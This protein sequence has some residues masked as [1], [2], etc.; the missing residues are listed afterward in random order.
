MGPI[1]LIVVLLPGDLDSVWDEAASL[2]ARTGVPSIHWW[3]ILGRFQKRLHTIYTLSI[4]HTFGCLCLRETATR[5][6][7]LRV[8]R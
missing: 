4:R 5:Y 3:R 6:R 8:L 1:L 7:D 2:R